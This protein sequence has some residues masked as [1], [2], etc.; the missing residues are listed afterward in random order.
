[1][2]MVEKTDFTIVTKLLTKLITINIA[3]QQ[4]QRHHHTIEA[5]SIQ[6]VKLPV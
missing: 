6:I 3:Q 1:M 2:M 4:Q 5:I